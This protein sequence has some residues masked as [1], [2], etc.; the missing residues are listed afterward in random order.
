MLSG[1]LW[2]CAARGAPSCA[3]SVE[4]CCLLLLILC[5][6]WKLPLADA[7]AVIALALSPDLQTL[8]TVSA[9]QTAF[10]FHM[11]GP[12]QLEPIGMVDL[13]Q[14]PTCLAWSPNSSRLLI[15]TR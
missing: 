4:Q 3:P 2:H 15:G 11:A 12:A 13:Q 6:H 5:S 14:V 1:R 10:L 7:D 9:D 8:A